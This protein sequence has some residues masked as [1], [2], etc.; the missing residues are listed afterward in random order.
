MPESFPASFGDLLRSLRTAAGLTQEELAEA[1]EVSYRSISDLE[2]GV[3][4]FPRKDTARLLADALGLSGDDR[5]RFEAAARGRPPAA[6]ALP[7]GIAAATRTLPRDIASFTGRER[8]IE[9]VL[10]AVTN[11][12][13]GGVVE[14][15]AIDGMAGIGKTALAVHAAHRVSGR[16]D[17][18]PALRAHARPA[19]RRSR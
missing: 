6:G 11:A 7:G 14:I 8:E 4:R 16:A 10:A 1:S 18:P 9:S 5:A 15:C 3:S 17:L 12:D 19:A 2:R 13:A